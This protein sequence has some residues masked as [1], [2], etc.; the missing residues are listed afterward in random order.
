MSE[1]KDSRPKAVETLVRRG[2]EKTAKMI[3][4]KELAS[5]EAASTPPEPTPPG[6]SSCRAAIDKDGRFCP[7]CDQGLCWRCLERSDRREIVD[8]FT[9]CFRLLLERFLRIMEGAR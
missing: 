4:D 5:I 9:E 1:W 6:C 7:V 3:V 8:H 2:L